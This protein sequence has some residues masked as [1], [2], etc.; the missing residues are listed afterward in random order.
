MLGNKHFYHEIIKKNVKAFGTVFNNITVKKINPETG[1]VV[2]QEKVPLA[3]GPKS[4]FLARLQED[5]NTE[6]KVSITMPRI[7]F[8][9]TDITYDVGRKTSPIQKYLQEGDAEAVRVQYMPVPY[10]LR[11]ELGI[12][13]RNQDD[14]LQI[15]E[16]ILPYFQPSFNLTVNLIP[17]MDEKKDLPI[18]LNNISYEDDYED[19]ILRRRTV[20]YTLDFTL[21]TYMYGPV[22]NSNLIKKATVFESIGDLNEHKRQLRYDVSARA[23][24]DKNQDGVIDENDDMLL[25]SGDDFGFNEGIEYL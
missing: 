3:Y 1:D 15:L 14:A 18:I 20:V 24:E 25:M 23:L 6:R 16:Q 9:M 19:D 8:E 2:R 21:K 12:L 7:S 22:T 4:K 13:S 17:E 10:N 5:P 11:F